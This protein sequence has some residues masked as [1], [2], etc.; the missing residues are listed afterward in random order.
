MSAQP[1]RCD[2]PEHDHLADVMVSRLDGSL[3]IA[4][5]DQAFLD[6]AAAMVAAA[7]PPETAPDAPEGSGDDS[8]PAQRPPGRSRRRS[9]PVPAV[10]VEEVDPLGGA[11]LTPDEYASAVA[12]GA[13][14]P[15]EPEPEREPEP[16]EA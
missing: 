3:A 4:L 2:A 7:M 13:L 10:A 14:E 1:I 16:V 5:C 12:Q 6:F 9:V 15:S 11:M 8:E